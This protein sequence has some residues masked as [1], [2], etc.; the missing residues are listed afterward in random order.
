[1]TDTTAR[2]ITYLAMTVKLLMCKRYFIPH[3]QNYKRSKQPGTALKVSTIPYVT[4]KFTFHNL[5]CRWLQLL[6]SHTSN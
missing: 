1:V 2:K 3:R 4:Q 5:Y 6:L